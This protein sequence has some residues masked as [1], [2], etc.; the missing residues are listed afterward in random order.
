MTLPP[1]QT[2]FDDHRATVHRFLVATLGPQ[3]ADDCFQ[4]TFLSALRAYP[5]LDGE[6]NMR[7]W[8]FTIAHR[9]V[10]DARRAGN[11]RPQPTELLPE[12]AVDPPPAPEPQ[13]WQA[14]RSLPPKQ[15]TAVLHRYLNDLSYPDIARILG[16]SQEAARQNVHQGLKKLRE[17]WER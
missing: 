8:I 10:I 2:F 11:R 3:E 13:L 12:P 16:C 1:F 7:A 9:K 5:R 4:E 6:S 17:V 14:V 15:G